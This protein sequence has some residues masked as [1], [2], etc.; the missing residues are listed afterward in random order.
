MVKAVVNLGDHEDRI[1]S[2]VKGKFGLHNKSDAIN[3]II[4]RYEEECMAPELRP[5]YREELEEADRG[6]SKKFTS[7]AD[8]RREIENV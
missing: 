8:L 6:R 4:D 3:L 2:I 7:I 1:V 5:E